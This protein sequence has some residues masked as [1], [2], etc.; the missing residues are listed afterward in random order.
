MLNQAV[1]SI[2]KFY[3][4]GWQPIQTSNPPPYTHAEILFQNQMSSQERYFLQNNKS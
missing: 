4:T 2:D 1:D 3:F